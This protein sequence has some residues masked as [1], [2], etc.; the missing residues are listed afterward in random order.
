MDC[1]LG[2]PTEGNVR[3]RTIKPWDC[4]PNLCLV[5][6]YLVRRQQ[7]TY[8]HLHETDIG[9]RELFVSLATQTMG[10]VLRLCPEM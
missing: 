8:Q 4:L 10:Q 7:P 6:S 1:S 2:R 5:P 9:P 3:I